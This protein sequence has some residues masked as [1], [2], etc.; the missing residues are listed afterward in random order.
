MTNSLRAKDRGRRGQPG[1]PCTIA[2]FGASGDLAT[3]KLFPA[4]LDLRRSN[5]LPDEF[6]VLGLATSDMSSAAFRE[7]L[8]PELAKGEG[9]E[10]AALQ[11]LLE[12]TT[13]QP[14]D[15]RSDDIYPRLEEGL[16]DAE[17]TFLTIAGEYRFRQPSY[18]FG[19]YLGLGGYE[20]AGDDFFEGEVD[21]R[22]LGLALGFT[23]DF[24]LR[25]IEAAQPQR[26]PRVVTDA[27]TEC[28]TRKRPQHPD[29]GGATPVPS[30][31]PLR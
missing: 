18:D 21:D 22:G 23:G 1:D 14:G 17:L 15:F 27:V 30:F 2:L 5:L 11:W 10:P 9:V 7:R 16:R 8:G 26:H 20:L 19:I 6:A 13:Y 3:R 31:R 4:L 12:R 29:R 25:A 24:D 28:A